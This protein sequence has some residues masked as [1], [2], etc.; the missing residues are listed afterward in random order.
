MGFLIEGSLHFFCIDWQTHSQLGHF[1]WD[2]N[3]Q[4][5]E[6]LQTHTA[7]LASSEFKHFWFRGHSQALGT[8]S[9]L[10]KTKGEWWAQVTRICEK[11]NLKQIAFYKYTATGRQR[12]NKDMAETQQKPSHI[13]S[14]VH[15]P[16]EAGSSVY[17]LAIWLLILPFSK[18]TNKIEK[19][20][21]RL[22][23]LQ[24]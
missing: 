4:N 6:S 19:A 17:T 18:K 5:T 15:Y 20:F 14:I 9:L 12:S 23:L 7:N 16:Q 22:G 8:H 24:R 21:W 2:W 1:R 13:L 11:K 10:R 3:S